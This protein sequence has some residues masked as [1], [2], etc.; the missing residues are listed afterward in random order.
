MP[1]RINL[2][3]LDHQPLHQLASPARRYCA[4]FVRGRRAPMYGLFGLHFYRVGIKDAPECFSSRQGSIT[5][6]RGQIVSAKLF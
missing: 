2:N 4:V 3:R 1:L 5:R 6:A